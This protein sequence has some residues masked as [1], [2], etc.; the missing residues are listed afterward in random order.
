MKKNQKKLTILSA[1]IIAGLTFSTL[2]FA[3]DTTPLIGKDLD[4]NRDLVTSVMHG[5][6]YMVQV[7]QQGKIVQIIDTGANGDGSEVNINNNNTANR[8]SD[9]LTGQASM[10]VTYQGQHAIDF[11]GAELPKIALRYGLDPDKLKEMLVNDN[12]MHID[13]NKNIVYVDN[14]SNNTAADTTATGVNPPVPIASSPQLANTFKLHS[15]PGASKTI[16]LDF[17]GYTATGTAWSST[18]IVAPAFDLSGNPAVFDN[19]EMSNIIS[20]WNSVS[21]DYIPFDVDVTT[22]PP[23]ADA[24]IRTSASDTTFGTRLVI[25]SS[26]KTLGCACGGISYVGVASLVNNTTLQPAWVF[27]DML[28]NTA[29]YIAEAASHEAGHTFGLFHDGWQS[30]STLDV[31]YYGYGSGE[32]GWAPIMGAGYYQNVTQWSMGAYPDANNKQDDVA[33]FAANGLPVRTD[34]VGD[35][36]KTAS[37]LTYTITGGKAN[38][39]TFGIISTPTDIDMY[40]FTTTGGTVTLSASPAATGPNLDTQLALYDA[41]GKLLVSSSP[42][43]TLK[44]SVTTTLANGA[45]YLA[46]SGSAR[47]V[48]GSTDFGYPTYGSLGRSSITGSYAAAAATPPNAAISV[49]ATTGAAAFTVYFDASQSIGNGNITGYL[50]NFGDGSATSNTAAPVHTYSTPGTY[51]ATLMITNQY[52]VTNTTSIVI[53][54]TTPPTPTTHNANLTLTVNKTTTAYSLQASITIKDANGIVVPN[55]KVTGVWS[56]AFT[57]TANVSTNANGI[58]TATSSTVPLTNAIRSGTFTITNVTANN[59]IYNPT[60]NVSSVATI[61]W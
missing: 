28:S 5:R 61:S 11:I 13:A 54:V 25:T 7:D 1:T 22:E 24:L 58:A 36:I 47:P 6:N 48:N 34:D 38:V 53:T 44:S 2:T 30:G 8:L 26:A 23:S 9:T 4:Q 60:L 37:S 27:Q 20:I 43:N 49:S 21:E 12:T 14:N 46:I 50:W 3:D 33:T 57:G 56:G 32:T 51:T 35:V 52:N 17:V 10:P 19:N 29:K 39:Q 31:Y 40:S 18:P 42:A 41:T 55:A 15:K 45:Y 16:Y 59:Y